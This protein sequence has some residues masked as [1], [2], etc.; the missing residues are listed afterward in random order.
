MFGDGSSAGGEHGEARF[1]V[2]PAEGIRPH[3]KQACVAVA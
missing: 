2:Q 1:A 3:Q